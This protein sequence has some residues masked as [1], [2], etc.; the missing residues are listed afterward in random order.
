M[1]NITSKIK[2][3]KNLSER[4]LKTINCQR[5]IEFN[6]DRE[7][8][9]DNKNAEWVWF[10][11]Y[12]KLE[13]LLSFGRLHRVNVQF[14]GMIYHILG[15]STIISLEKAK[16][17]GSIVMKN[18]KEYIQKSDTTAI[19]FCNPKNSEFYKKCGYLIL[20]NGIGRFIYLDENDIPIPGL[21][22][23]LFYLEGKD[24]LIAKIAS[25]QEEKV[26]SFKVQW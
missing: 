15:I 3:G 16:G 23:D 5:K 13:E 11:V 14:H 25:N 10:L 2:L 22:G 18:M 6:S 17:Y 21:P 20:K 7:I 1:N 4:D 8:V 12:S 24:K 26:T 9:L 19:E